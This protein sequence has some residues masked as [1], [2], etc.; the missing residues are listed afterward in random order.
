MVK[1][2]KIKKTVAMPLFFV[3]LL[4]PFF[5]IVGDGITNLNHYH[6]AVKILNKQK[7]ILKDKDTYNT[8][9]AQPYGK[10][11]RFINK[12]SKVKA[13]DITKKVINLKKGEKLE[14]N[15]KFP[16]HH[17]LHWTLNKEKGIYPEVYLND[18]LISN[19]LL[20]SPEKVNSL[21]II[22]QEDTAIESVYLFPETQVESKPDILFIVIDSLRAD[23]LGVMGADFGVSPN[24]DKFAKEA[25]VYKKHLVNASWTRP[26]TM[27]FLTG[28]YASK[29]YLNF[30]DYPV[31]KEEIQSFY[32]SPIQ[33]L[34]AVLGSAGYKTE[35]IGNN[36]F[37][38]D[39]YSIGADMGF[40][41]VVD[42]S[43]YEN[44]TIPITT[45]I[46]KYIS[47]IDSAKEKRRPEFVFLNYNDPHKPYTPP[48]QFLAQVKAHSSM[49]PRKRDY[50]GEV[51][52]IDFELGKV[53]NLLKE[54]N[55]YDDML[56]IVTADHGEVMHPAHAKSKFNGVYTLYGHG[57]GLYE[58]D[59]HVPL[60]IKYP[61]QKITK[62]IEQVSRSI[63]LM[64]T[65]LSIAKA[66]PPQTMEGMSL[67]DI[68]K[69]T[70]ERI[71]YGESRG[72]AGVRANGFKY[73]QK[74]FRFHRT[75][76]HWDGLVRDEPG[77]LFDLQKDPEETIPIINEKK[78][79]ELEKLLFYFQKKP[80]LYG[81]RI[82]HFPGEEG[83]EVFVS[84]NA[85][86][87]KAI[88]S[89]MNGL[90][91]FQKDFLYDA[92]GFHLK[93]VFEKEE[94]MEFY[95]QVY[96]DISFPK[97]NIT[98]NGSPI[99]KGEFGVGE[100]DI[101]PK[102]CENKLECA[103]IYLVKNKRPDPPKKF[104]VQFWLESKALQFS[105]DKGNLEK[106]AIDILKKQGYIK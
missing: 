48:P 88:T 15:I 12:F 89:D 35:M 75:G 72:V 84:I 50:L 20:T 9:I 83:K 76:N 66:K 60:L 19:H 64:P 22:A 62:S 21:K 81:V 1:K 65:I 38:T 105:S 40:E 11:S 37:M 43:H 23:V 4:L 90:P 102:N 91:L 56:I 17:K 78:K 59:I 61:N 68:E 29:T 6:P 99:K 55:L 104:R 33:P 71:Y 46:S 86:T 32:K 92:R 8:Y 95:F 31:F 100:K 101:Y 42:Y 3:L 69:E 16:L 27:V 53:F 98:V 97:I 73:M 26:S 14:F 36:P 87:G 47:E 49:D 44:D 10:D 34:G 28:M 18:S 63:D 7:G 85:N 30:W 51:A 106:D 82:T 96:P 79:E 94:S 2:N 77:Y 52:F 13:V 39:H 54:K 93:K 57:Q 70:S 24:L 5:V 103:E 74:T 67:L 41:E 45:K 80:S 25:T 58:E